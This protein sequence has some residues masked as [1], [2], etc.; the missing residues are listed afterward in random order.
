MGTGLLLHGRRA[1][2]S[3]LPV[4]ISLS[5][6]RSD[7]GLSV[8]VVVRDVSERLE[9]EA[10]LQRAEQHL[11][12]VEDRERIA[13]DLHD[14]VIQKLFAAGMTVQ[15]VAARSSNS[16]QGGRLHRVVDELDDTIREI[17][18]VIFSLQAD[19]RDQ[20]GLRAD[21]LRVADDERAALGFEPRIRFDGPVDATS[22]VVAAELI[23]AL[24]EALS[25]VARH[26]GATAVEVDV[27]HRDGM[28]TLRVVDDGIGLG[29]DSSGGNGLRNLSQRATKLGGR[30]VLHA[31][32]D[33]GT[34]LE[35][36][37]PDA[38]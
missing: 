5:P 11:R 17:R 13:R 26:A 34:V 29:A 1:D 21:V 8:V 38:G 25:N 30:C 19:A 35:W 20:S 16:E 14:V 24:R 7:A 37:V 23:P 27:Q 32:A 28:V 2:G 3:E 33:C 18:S 6:L 4:E 9:A 12:I 36:Q 22:N 15:G 10:R 31:V